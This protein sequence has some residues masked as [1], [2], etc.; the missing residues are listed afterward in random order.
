MRYE[1]LNLVGQFSIASPYLE[2]AC[3]F[4]V[5]MLYLSIK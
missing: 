5:N 2:T 3:F 4:H 1:S